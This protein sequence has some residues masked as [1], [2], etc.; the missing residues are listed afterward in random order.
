MTEIIIND[1]I[2]KYRELYK[3]NR[4]LLSPAL[5][6]EIHFNSEGFNHLLFKGG[7]KRTDKAIINRLPLVPLAIP[8]IKNCKKTLEIRSRKETIKGKDVSVKYYSLEANVGK[9]STRVRVVIRKIGK[10]GNYNFF[11]IMKYN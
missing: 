4:P 8:V 11:S 9:S 6:Q 2:D 1:F 3:K 5:K 7:K 10:N